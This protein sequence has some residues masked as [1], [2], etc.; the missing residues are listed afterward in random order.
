MDATFAVFVC[1]L[2]VCN[3]LMQ[4]IMGSKL[5]RILICLTG[6][7]VTTWLILPWA[8]TKVVEYTVNYLIV[9]L[10]I[11]ITIYCLISIDSQQSKSLI[12]ARRQ[13]SYAFLIQSIFILL[14]CISI[15]Y[16]LTYAVLAALVGGAIAA[17]WLYDTTAR[18]KS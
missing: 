5:W 10:L 7:G 11:P 2:V 1:A 18:G 3:A 4:W 16:A 12:T 13:I 6:I 17:G 14:Y 15:Y 9:I 8:P